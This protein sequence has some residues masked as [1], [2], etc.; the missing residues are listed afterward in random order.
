M[1][2]I[3]PDVGHLEELVEAQ[4]KIALLYR[5]NRQLSEELART[6]AALALQQMQ[7][8]GAQIEA[9]L[10]SVRRARQRSRLPV[11]R[12]VLH[13]RKIRQLE[14]FDFRWYLGQYPDVDSSGMRPFRHFVLH[15]VFE[16]RDPSPR[17][18]T[19]RY[20]ERYLHMLGPA[21]PAIFHYVSKGRAMGLHPL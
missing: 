19:I 10:Q 20:M 5:M 14:L 15:G 9:H 7:E 4:R 3:A 2:P 8:L 21:E 16:G 1:H 12:S 18:N 13:S 11:I 6:Q 17:F